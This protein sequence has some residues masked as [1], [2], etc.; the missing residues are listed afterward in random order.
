ML[1]DLELGQE[2]RLDVDLRELGLAV[3]A[4]IL[5][6]IALAD[7]VVAVEARHHQHLLEQLRR[8]R[9]RVEHAVV[10]A[11]RHE[12]FARALGCGLVERRRLD[13][14]EAQCVEVLARRHRRAVAQHHVLL[15]LRP[16]QIEHAILEAHGLGQVLVV[17]LER[18][19]QRR[20]EDRDLVR[21]HLDLARYQ[22]RVDGAFP[23]RPDE[24]GDADDELVAQALGRGEGR[25]TVGVADDLDEAFAIAQV[26][27][28][29]AAVVAAAMDPA[30][31]RDGLAEVSAVDA[32][33]IIG[34]VQGILRKAADSMGRCRGMRGGQPDRAAA[35][36]RA[37]RPDLP[38]QFRGC[39][40]ASAPTGVDGA[41]VTGRRGACART[42]RTGSVRQAAAR[43]HP[44]R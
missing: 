25:R 18:R 27:E 30:H 31:Q 22:V 36:A 10:D 1:A 2:R 35:I 37:G 8:L 26:D 24:A 5:V 4:Q 28:D 32:A 23:A 42:G 33:A 14:D 16:A 20:V 21:E 12:E 6:A 39:A 38:G 9:Q 11:R 34:A 44:S 40:A 7:L 17:E 43:P 3:G 19:R 41:A 15:H 29:D 13:V